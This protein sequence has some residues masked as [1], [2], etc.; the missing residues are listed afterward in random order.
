MKFVLIFLK[1]RK[2]LTSISLTLIKGNLIADHIAISSYDFG[3][4]LKKQM[5]VI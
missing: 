5:K 3:I 2:Y 1:K 4:N